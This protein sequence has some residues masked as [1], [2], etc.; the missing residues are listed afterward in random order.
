VGGSGCGR[1]GS[2]VGQEDAC[3]ADGQTDGAANGTAFEGLVV[4]FL[5]LFFGEELHFGGIVLFFLG[6]L[7]GRWDG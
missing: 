2:G 4:V 7:V 5:F 1:N 6:L 3:S